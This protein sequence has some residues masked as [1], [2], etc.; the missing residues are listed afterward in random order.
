MEID[1]KKKLSSRK[2]WAALIA[3]ITGILTAFNVDT[4]TTNQVVT[5][6]AGIGGLIAYIIG[7]SVIDAKAISSQTTIEPLIEMKSVMGFTDKE[8]GK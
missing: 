5:I 8:D 2:F 4:M 6:V 3:V 7:E 1:W